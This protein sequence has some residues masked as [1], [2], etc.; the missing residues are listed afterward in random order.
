MNDL[1]YIILPVYNRK[2]ITINFIKKLNNQT[3]KNFKLI[4]VD[5]GSTD[6]TEEEVKKEIEDIIVLK[7]NGNLWWGGALH[8]AYNYIKKSNFDKNHFVL[9][10]NDDTDIEENFLENGLNILKNNTNSIIQAKGYSLKEKNKCVDNGAFID[11]TNFTFHNNHSK[12]NCFT[13]RGL[14]MR[15]KDFLNIGGFYPILLPHYASD[16]EYTFRFYKKGYKLITDDSFKIWI[17]DETTGISMINLYK[18]PFFTFLKKTFS[19]RCIDNPI[20]LFNLVLIS[21]PMKYKFQN[22]LRVIKR[23]IISILKYNEKR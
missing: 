9:I 20:T 19:K 13:T 21:S 23:A 22:L 4:L 6:A 14:L 5:D 12:I 11:W 1:I 3:Y 7:G 17:N 15:L 2:D 8:K 18:Y 10:I 16:I